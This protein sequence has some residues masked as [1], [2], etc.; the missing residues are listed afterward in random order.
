MLPVTGPKLA[1]WRVMRGRLFLSG[2]VM[3]LLCAQATVMAQDNPPGAGFGVEANLI[4]GKI[5]KHTVNF[6]GPVPAL[7]SGAEINFLQ[8]TYGRKPWHIRRGFPVLGFGIAYTNYGIDSIYGKC[9]SI[10]PNVQF[11]LARR[12]RLEWTIRTGFGG[13]FVTRH[14]ERVPRWDTLNNA[15]GSHL[16]NFTIFVT[17]L[18]YRASDRL[19]LQLGANFT[20]ISNAAFRQPNL[21]VN[22]YGGHVGIRYYP[23]TARVKHSEEVPPKLPNRWLAQAKL[24]LTATES[25]LADGPLYPVYLASAYAS[26]RWRSDNKLLLGFDYSYHAKIYAFL[27]NN[28]I[29]PGEERRNSWKGSVFVGNEFLFGHI[30]V[31]LQVGYYLKDAYLRLSPVY[32]KLGGNFY[33]VQKEQG[34]LKELFVTGL[35]KTHLTQAELAEFGVGFG[36]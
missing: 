14:Y 28:E 29:L 21:G 34:L 5:I 16:N 10:Y 25:G 30:G 23:V 27:R 32:Q 26:R 15:V 2:L 22:M 6:K 35:L 13:G 3:G 36:F 17:D 1:R 7:S 20:H 4:A 9:I 24:G 11:T 12:G 31:V 33:L 18:R 8:R 19:E